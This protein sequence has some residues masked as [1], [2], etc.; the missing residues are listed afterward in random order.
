M[1]EFAGPS[2]REL[3]HVLRASELL[4]AEMGDAGRVRLRVPRHRR[5]SEGRLKD[6]PIAGAD[7]FAAGREHAEWIAA[8]PQKTQHAPLIIERKLGKI[9]PPTFATKVPS[10]TDPWPVV[11]MISVSSKSTLSPLGKAGKLI[12]RP[13]CGRRPLRQASESPQITVR[14]TSNVSRPCRCLP[15]LLPKSSVKRKMPLDPIY[16]R[17]FTEAQ[18]DSLPFRSSPS[19]GFS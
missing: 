9:A 14:H 10:R 19:G 7:L 8:P 13:L 2:I 15:L 17:I 1:F 6:A 12:L 5:A 18:A 16:K 4:R 3:E 11:S